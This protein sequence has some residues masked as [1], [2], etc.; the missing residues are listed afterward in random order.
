[1]DIR[2]SLESIDQPHELVRTSKRAEAGEIAGDLGQKHDLVTAVGGDGTVHEVAQGIA[3]TASILGLVPRGSGNDFNRFLGMPKDA[4]TAARTLARSSHVISADAAYVTVRSQVSGIEVQRWMIN[5]LGI[6]YDAAVAFR[7]ERVPVLKGLPLY[8]TSALWTLVHARPQLF[9][10]SLDD[11]PQRDLDGFMVCLGIG[12]FEGG[13]FKV[14]PNAQQDD[15]LLD[16]CEVDGMAK[17]RLLP[18]LIRAI[19]GKHASSVGVRMSLARRATISSRIPF[20]VHADGELL[21]PNATE[22]EIE[23]KFGALRVARPSRVA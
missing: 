4:P 23:V 14:L 7:R 2:R 8:L 6:G 13:G 16:V 21:C 18:L 1:M 19:G 3:G 20:P 11:A 5:T 15:G 17:H 10:V 9:K 22:V 12:K